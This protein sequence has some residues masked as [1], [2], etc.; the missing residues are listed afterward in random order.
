M[1]GNSAN[2]VEHLVEKK[3]AEKLAQL[4]E[5]KHLETAVAAI[6]GLGKVGGEAAVNALVSMLHSPDKQIRL[7]T[8]KAMGEMK[9]PRTRMHVSHQ[10]S[11]EADAEV[12]EALQVALHS[13][14][15]DVK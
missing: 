8:A 7:A 6:G 10:M 5:D 9:D 13:I 4:A 1:F 12:K 3:N 14:T 11:I 2:K 15:S